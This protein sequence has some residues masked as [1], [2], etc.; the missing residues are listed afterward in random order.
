[1]EPA[2]EEETKQPGTPEEMSESEYSIDTSIRKKK[3]QTPLERAYQ[4]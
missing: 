1:M 2:V 4:P 3:K